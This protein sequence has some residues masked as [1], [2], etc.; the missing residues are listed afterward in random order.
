VAVILASHLTNDYCQGCTCETT[1]GLAIHL[2]RHQGHAASM[3]LHDGGENEASRTLSSKSEQGSVI[4]E[5]RGA[6]IPSQA[7]VERR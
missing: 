3:L 4:V 1:I 5:C 2:W 7:L 6:A